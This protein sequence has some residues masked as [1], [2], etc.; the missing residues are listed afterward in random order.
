MGGW[1]NR[2]PRNAKSISRTEEEEEQEEEDP[3]GGV[4]DKKESKFWE[5]LPRSCQRVSSSYTIT[6][7]SERY[8]INKF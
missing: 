4:N 2:S 5:V 1:V 7:G 6:C 3:E 8:L